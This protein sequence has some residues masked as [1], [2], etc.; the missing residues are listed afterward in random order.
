MRAGKT[1]YGHEAIYYESYEAA[2]DA[3]ILCRSETP[4]DVS[5]SRDWEHVTCK[6]CLK[7][8]EAETR[9]LELKNI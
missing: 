5:I 6:N 1:H 2:E 4:E 3:Y 8:R 9:S 7:R